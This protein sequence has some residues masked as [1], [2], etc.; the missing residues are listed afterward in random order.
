[1]FKQLGFSHQR[2]LL[3]SQSGVTLTLL[4]PKGRQD[5][6]EFKGKSHS[7]DVPLKKKKC[8][9]WPVNLAIFA[10]NPLCLAN[11]AR[12]MLEQ[13]CDCETKGRLTPLISNYVAEKLIILF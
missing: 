4:A 5:L 3:L 11:M 2:L 6:P 7:V 9:L 10:S 12:K 8:W 13:S 1:M